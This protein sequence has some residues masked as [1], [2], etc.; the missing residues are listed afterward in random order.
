MG[1][2]KKA[3][4]TMTSRERVLRTFAYEKTDRVPI[5]Y[6]ANPTIH[7]KTMAAFD[8]DGNEEALLQ[9]LGVDFRS[10]YVH[11]RGPLIYPE[12][13]GASVN[14]MF[15]FYTKWIENEY[16]G[17]HD[18]CH[19]PLKDADDE[20]IDAFK[21]PSA[22]DFDYPSAIAKIN[23]CGEYALYCASPGFADIINSTGQLMG[24]EDAL[25]QIHTKNAATL[26]LIDRRH[27]LELVIVERLLDKAK[28]RIDFMWI[29]E[30]LG[31]QI[32]P[33]I[34]LDLY[35]SVLRPRHQRFVDLA[36]SYNIPVMV[37]TCG[38][39]SWVYE[40]FIEMGIAA[41]DALQPEAR[42]MSPEY[43]CRQFGKRLSFHGCISTAGALAY[44]KPEEVAKVCKDTLEIMRQNG[45]Y[46]FA[47]TH[48][49]QDNTPVEN[50]IAMYQAAHDYG[51]W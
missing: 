48:Y 8:C 17:Y 35:R 6:S 28:G 10:T 2:I 51:V 30:D 5:N 36:K 12:I 15:G 27:D 25:V 47:P 39:S 29:G 42:D 34:G 40:D 45:G 41:V 13:L 4:E 37:H 14:P 32:A 38:S 9:A 26:N 23:A 33:M 19:F 31:T 7:K 24:M 44:G 46:H 22:D 50:I 11:Y 43:L 16:G 3:A 49:I 20:E 18:L 1:I 21:F